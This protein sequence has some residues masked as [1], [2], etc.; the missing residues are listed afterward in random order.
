MGSRNRR[1]LVALV[2]IVTASLAGAPAVHAAGSPSIRIVSTRDE[3][4]IKEGSGGGLD[5]GVWIAAV[6]GDFEI[7]LSRP[8]YLTDITAAQTT[9]TGSVIREIPMDDLLG[10]Y[11]FANFLHVSV[12]NEAGRAVYR[13]VESFC[14]GG[15]EQ[16]R[17][18]DSGPANP[19]Y[20]QWCGGNPFTLS[21]VWGIDRGWAA[22]ALQWTRIPARTMPAGHYD[23]RV[24]IDPTFSDLFQIPAGDAEKH[25]AVTVKRRLG[26]TDT[27]AAPDQAAAPERFDSVPVISPSSD[28]V[29]DMAAL[30][31]WG[32]HAMHRRGHD[33]LTFGSTVWNGGPSPMIVEGYRQPD[34]DVMDGWQY[35]TDELGNVVGKAEVGQL[36]YDSRTGHEH[37]HFEQFA[38]YALMDGT[39]TEVVRSD[40]VSFCLAPTDPIDLLLPTAEWVPYSTGFY[41]ACG[42]PGSLWVRE[43]LPVGWGD[44]YYQYLPGQS[45]DITDLPN[46]KYFVRVQVNPLGELYDATSANDTSYRRVRLRGKPGNRRAVV[47]PYQGIDTDGCFGCFVADGQPPY[48]GA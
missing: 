35:F 10:W 14:P 31:A 44:T 13:T 41:S 15:W 5:L 38:N 8:D 24:W 1:S 16:D 22:N 19:T 30:P 11:G 3:I 6:D 9:S 45:F 32:V 2:T 40:K 7:R 37:W 33:Y 26:S 25:I 46:G 4:T 42:E 36:E 18:D 20:P 23:V 43:T 17:I 39:K 12:K 28:V 29:P 21:T 48:D 27:T 34:S 47:P